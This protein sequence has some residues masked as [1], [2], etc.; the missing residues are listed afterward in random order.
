MVRGP[1][2]STAP[3]RSSH[4][5]R[6]S[7]L[8]ACPDFNFCARGVGV[9]IVAVDELGAERSASRKPTVVLPEPETPIND[10]REGAQRQAV[11]PPST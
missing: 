6:S 3:T 8:S 2:A 7:S 11:M 4:G 10:D 1:F 5:Q 9:E